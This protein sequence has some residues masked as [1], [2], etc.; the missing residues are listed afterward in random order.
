MTQFE[1]LLQ[2][3][4]DSGVAVKED[5]RLPAPFLGLYL[6][7]EN[8][9]TIILSP[10][11]SAAGKLCVLA[12]EVAHYE[13]AIG[14]MRTL[15]PALNHLQEK[16]ALSL[17]IERLI[18]FDALARAVHRFVWTKYAAAEHF[19]VTEEFIEQAVEHYRK[20]RPKQLWQLKRYAQ[21][22]STP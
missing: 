16:R 7:Y 5:P 3:M 19:G 6:L 14:D 20:K 11:L 12:E 13:T 15:P 10:G 1:E 18:P 17:A 8:Q 21:R 4:E 2:Q 9:H 22:N